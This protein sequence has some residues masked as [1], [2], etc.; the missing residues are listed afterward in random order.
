[1]TTRPAFKVRVHATI[2]SVSPL[3]VVAISHDLCFIVA[4]P[5]DAIIRQCMGMVSS[6]LYPTRRT[7]A[8]ATMNIECLSN[9]AGILAKRRS[10]P[11][12][13][14]GCLSAARVLR[15]LVLDM[16]RT[17]RPNLAHD[18]RHPLLA[19][20]R[21][22]DKRVVLRSSALFSRGQSPK[23][24]RL[25][26]YSDLIDRLRRCDPKQCQLKQIIIQR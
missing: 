26:S 7:C 9:I 1:M 22:P 17:I 8:P 13:Q 25:E 20:L 3:L 11:H 21:K 16:D 14:G 5:Q 19:G 2:H 12:Q 15:L 18:A 6:L 4:V 23:P 24:W 10:N